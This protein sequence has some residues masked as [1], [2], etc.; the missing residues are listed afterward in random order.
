VRH[1]AD[2]ELEEEAVVPEQLVLEEDLL[3]HL[4]GRPDEVRTAQHRGGVV[5]ET[6]QRWPPALAADLVHRRGDVGERFVER[7]LRRLGDVA[8]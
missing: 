8:V 6:L 1:P 4:L 2:R 3:D 7:A 5:V